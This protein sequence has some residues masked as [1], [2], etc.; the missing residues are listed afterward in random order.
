LE[1]VNRPEIQAHILKRTPH[2]SYEDIGGL[3]PQ[4]DQ[5]KKLINVAYL[6]SDLHNQYQLDPPKGILL[7][8]PPGCGKTLIAKAVANFVIRQMGT[9]NSRLASG[10]FLHAKGPELLSRYVGETERYLRLMFDYSRDRASRGLPTIMFF[11]EMDSLFRDR[12]L[13]SASG[14]EN[15]VV[16]QLLSLLDGLEPLENVIVLGATN[17][18]DMIDPA[19][20]RAGRFD[21]KMRIGR[22]DL[23][24]SMEIFAKHLKPTLPLAP[25]SLELG[26]G[27]VN[28]AVERLI[29][30]TVQEI[31]TESDDKF[32]LEVTF[33][34]GDRRTLFF[35]DFLSGAVI[36]N[37]VARAKAYAIGRSLAGGPNGLKPSDLLDA[38]RDEVR[39]N[40]DLPHGMGSDDWARIS[41]EKGESI[42]SARTI[43]GASIPSSALAMRGNLRVP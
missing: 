35:K 19:V 10:S 28:L 23:Q 4:I 6:R 1:R 9:N 38:V 33:S 31:Y 36:K 20:L 40:E 16:P 43:K 8:G 15:T 42:V 18:E 3:Q 11:D 5:L 2:E 41:G 30:G 21:I 12:Q 32:F 29:D 27:D 7:Y 37:I 22:P 39:E 13:D 34:N 17:R 14:I 26:N 24:G 25:E